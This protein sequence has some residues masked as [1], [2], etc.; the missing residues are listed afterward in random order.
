MDGVA[1]TRIEDQNFKILSCLEVLS[2]KNG[3][4]TLEENN[5][6]A[7]IEPL[8]WEG[9]KKDFMISIESQINRF[10]VSL[11]QKQGISKMDFK[12]DNN[13]QYK[14][15]CHNIN[16]RIFAFLLQPINEE[17]MKEIEK[18]SSGKTYLTGDLDDMFKS[19]KDFN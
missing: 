1:V 10:I 6:K 7:L 5:I 18:N 4:T 11:N 15:L 12:G 9:C 14:L 2:F 19:K 13:Q 16:P 3:K 8:I 17:E